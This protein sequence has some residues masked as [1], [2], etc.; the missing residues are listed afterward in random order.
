[1]LPSGIAWTSWRAVLA[2][3]G[4]LLVIF[5]L[6]RCIYF[7]ILL[8]KISH[9]LEKGTLSFLLRTSDD[10]CSTLKRCILFII[11]PLSLRVCLFQKIFYVSC[12]RN[13]DRTNISLILQFQLISQYGVD[14]QI[15]S[16]VDTL[17]FYIVPVANPDGYEY[18]R[19]DVTPQV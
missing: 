5:C 1:M 18:S 13:F 2:G 19:S 14:P 6:L 15:T 7:I 10:C 3:N 9:S 8:R 11:F 4:L 16:Y 17:N 12:F